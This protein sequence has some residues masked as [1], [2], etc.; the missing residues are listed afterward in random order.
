MARSEHAGEVVGERVARRKEI[1]VCD[2]LL[3]DDP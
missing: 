1:T 3:T 2:D